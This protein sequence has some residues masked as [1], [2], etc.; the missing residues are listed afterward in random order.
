MGASLVF[1]FSIGLISSLHCAAMCGPLVL[2]APFQVLPPRLRW[3]GT[4]LYH[5][6]R[7]GIYAAGG[8][9]FG[10]AGRAIYLAGQQHLLSILLGTAILAQLL[11]RRYSGRGWMPRW[12]SSCY[13]TLQ[14][15]MRRWWASP[16]L[17]KFLL[18]GVGNGLLPCSMVYL[19]IAGALTM[20]GAAKAMAFMAMFGIG[21]L[22]LLLGVQV[23]GRISGLGTRQRFRRL[24]P[25]LTAAIACL[26]ICRGLNLGIPF[27]SPVLADKP[28]TPVTCH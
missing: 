23:A 2:A 20:N 10:L 4:G 24:V 8:L 1:A 26:L 15:V 16:S 13:L 27:I 25:L 17:A 11:F 5:S 21:T 18:L 7:I 22:P 3:L 14:R 6:G 9:V 28:G 19:A 12:L